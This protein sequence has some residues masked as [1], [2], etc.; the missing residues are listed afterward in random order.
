MYQRRRSHGMSSWSR[1]RVPPSII[2]I[3]LRPPE[4]QGR[5][6]R[7]TCRGYL[8]MSFQVSSSRLAVTLRPVRQV[9]PCSVPPPE[10][11]RTRSVWLSRQRPSRKPSNLSFE[12]AASVP[13]ASQTALGGIFT[14]GHLEKGQTILIH[15]GAGAAGPFS[16]KRPF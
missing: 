1:S 6:F 9:K 2:W 3:L 15:G 7:S 16:R 12:E 13:V 8:V 4:R 11:A 14:H 10:L 5:Y